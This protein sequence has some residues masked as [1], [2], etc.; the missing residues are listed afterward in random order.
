MLSLFNKS[1]VVRLKPESRKPAAGRV[2]LSYLTGP[3]FPGQEA[4]SRG[5]TNWQ[6]CRAMAEVWLQRG[7]AVDVL[8]RKDRRYQPPADT[9]V[10]IDIGLNLERWTPALPATSHR[11][12]H[13]TGAHW[14]R[15]NSA[16]LARL[17]AL[18]E[19]RGLALIPRRQA[20]PHR[21]IESA[22]SAT[23]LGNEFTSESYAFAGKPMTRIPISTAYQFDW[24]AHKDWEK[25]RTRFLWVG[26]LGMVH[27]GLDLVLEAVARH[28]EWHL[29]VCGRPEKE[30]D[31]WNAYQREL[32]GL[33]QISFA[34]WMDMASPEF[35]QIRT[36]CG[37]LVYPSCSEGGGGAV[38]HCQ[39]AGLVP[40]ATREASVDLQPFG[41]EIST[42]TVEAVES[43][44]EEFAAGSAANAESRA[45][46]SWEYVRTIHTI[47][48]FRNAYAQFVDHLIA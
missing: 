8:D 27:K 32:T 7:Y 33:P 14:L 28:P 29:T 35:E 18:Q 24:P 26:S 15:Q 30:P 23:C 48:S 5:H 11:I 46:A 45:R 22:T 37:A 39:H 44:M 43:A 36:N 17:G 19:R 13:A 16:E 2:V 34:G 9:R 10:V 21:G 31:F 41:I 20:I 47:D 6:E 1:Q 38:I 25:S 42:G 3:F 12:Y 40:I 4:A